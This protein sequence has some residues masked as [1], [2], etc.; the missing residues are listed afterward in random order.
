MRSD[1]D[2]GD[3]GQDV[4]MMS[5]TSRPVL[6]FVTRGASEP[7]V[8][9]LTSPQSSELSRS[10]LVSP[11]VEAAAKTMR[12]EMLTGPSVP[13]AL[14]MSSTGAVAA[15]L[16]KLRAGGQGERELRALRAAFIRFDVDSSNTIN[17][18]ELK[19]LMKH[20][21]Y[22]LSD[23]DLSNLLGQIAT[24]GR[25]EL[26]FAETAQLMHMYKEAAQFKL[27][28]MDPEPQ[29]NI[30][31]KLE[32]LAALLAR[33]FPMRPCDDPIIGAWESAMVLA[34]SYFFILV[35]YMHTVDDRHLLN[36]FDWN[37]LIFV[38]FWL[39][40]ALDLLVRRRIYAERDAFDGIAD[41]IDV[42]AAVPIEVLI[43][44]GIRGR[45][46]GT[47]DAQMFVALRV[48]MSFKMLKIL[49][50]W[51]YFAASGLQQVNRR[52]IILYAY[53]IPGISSI[54]YF[55]CFAQLLTIIWYYSASQHQTYV[56]ALY[57]TSYTITGVGYGT[58]G[59]RTTLERL[60]AAAYCLVAVAGVAYVV[61]SIVNVMEESDV[62]GDGEHQVLQ[63]S[64]ICRIGGVAE[65][66]QVD[67]INF[68]SHLV[69]N[70]LADAY[71]GLVANLPTEL[72]DNITLFVKVRL[73]AS[74]SVFM[75]AHRATQV[76]LARVLQSAI[77]R[78]GEALFLEGDVVHDM[79]FIGHG[80]VQ[81]VDTEGQTEEILRSGAHLN[82]A[83]LLFG[84]ETKLHT[85]RCITH[86]EVFILNK[87]AFNGIRL[88]FPVF[89]IEMQR[90]TQFLQERV[91]LQRML[92]MQADDE[93]RRN[94]ERAATQLAESTLISVTTATAEPSA[95]HMDG[96]PT[97]MDPTALAQAASGEQRSGTHEP[98]RQSIRAVPK[99]DFTFTT[100]TG[101]KVDLN[102]VSA[103]FRVTAA[104]SPVS[105]RAASVRHRKA[106]SE[107][108]A[109]MSSSAEDHL[110]M[111]AL[112]EDTTFGRLEMG[113]T[114]VADSEDGD[115]ESVRNEEEEA[116]EA[117]F[118]ECESELER[119]ESLVVR[120][121]SLRSG[122]L[123]ANSNY[124]VNS[125]S[126]PKHSPVG[127][128][129]HLT[130]MISSPVVENVAMM[131]RSPTPDREAGE[132][133]G[134]P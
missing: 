78:P 74:D 5:M 20:L 57:F 44:A 54:C 90:I 127:S 103:T 31:P 111:A 17:K 114:D 128:T 89:D 113:P 88:R 82:E 86:C 108:P 10:G 9:I 102:K 133:S 132:S 99:V 79:V 47:N 36:V 19:E 35:L 109:N 18:S 4:E 2:D 117:M 94:Q 38:V 77:M 25:T 116:E 16:A 8:N 55:A 106:G 43:Y 48:V 53:V 61:G 12:R 42:I 26:S 11:P 1:E 97:P 84:A 110:R 3:E 6:R 66:L 41:A 45:S 121:T 115:R 105:G 129:Q 23:E 130:S 27:L 28:E 39:C 71:G 58:V 112:A 81:L 125:T 126:T 101:K 95:E 30:D 91:E 52:Y 59:A 131:P 134:A 87:K 33:Y 118:V 40:F 24:D 51:R 85:A 75:L 34:A 120:L 98:K 72:R 107:S 56:E 100:T 69:R 65:A 67:A 119:I 22:Q 60:V 83:A 92:E 124:T 70:K 7:D 50:T 14:T 73:V 123:F 49:S 21:G 13:G 93:E 76:A 96:A 122:T 62:Q 29:R 46:G 15:T 37:V 104:A 64:R 32:G 80:V 68:Q 63:T